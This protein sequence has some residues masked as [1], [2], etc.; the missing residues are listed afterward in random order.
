[1]YYTYCGVITPVK[2]YYNVEG[3]VS[4]EHMII[5]QPCEKYHTFYYTHILRAIK[6]ENKVLYNI[7]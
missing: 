3:R 5:A 2:V 1:M 4:L 6:V 7:G